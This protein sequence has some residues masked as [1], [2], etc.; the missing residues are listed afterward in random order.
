MIT[1]KEIA[2]AMDVEQVFKQNRNRRR[3]RQFDY[4]ST[5]EG[6]LSAEQAF[7]TGYF[8]W[9]T[10]QAIT[11]MNTRF[12]QLQQY[13]TLFRFLCNINTMRQ[14]ND[15]DFL[16]CCL[17]LDL[18][19]CSESSRDMDGADLCAEHKIFREIVPESVR[20]AIQCLQYLWIIRDSF[21]NT[22][23]A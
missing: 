18:V 1:A 8:L 6:M 16:K 3:K 23:I 19:L 22:A 21:P 12:E 14:L 7:R 13:D 5:D 4:E 10:Y 9:I 11:S 2:S 20:T 15:D 17:N